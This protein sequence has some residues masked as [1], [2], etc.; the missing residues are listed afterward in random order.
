M[1]L[2]IGLAKRFQS[3]RNL[4]TRLPETIFKHINNQ[5]KL[6]K[7]Q[8]ALRSQIRVRILSSM[9]ERMIQKIVSAEGAKSIHIQL[10]WTDALPALRAL[11]VTRSN[12]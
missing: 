7:K 3:I 2:P 10:S 12:C 11:A 8:S 1:F 9:K 6:I 4:R 5:T